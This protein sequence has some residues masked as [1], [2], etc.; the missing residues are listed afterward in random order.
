MKHEIDE[1]INADGE[2]QVVRKK[3]FGYVA[4]SQ[5][6]GFVEKRYSRCNQTD[7]EKRHEIIADEENQ[8]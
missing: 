1:V 5:R 6:L 3:C 8:S 7:D 4:D 2:K